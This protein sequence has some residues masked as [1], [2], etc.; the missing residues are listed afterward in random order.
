MYEK[1]RKNISIDTYESKQEAI[2]KETYE[3][4]ETKK[5]ER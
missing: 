3:Q 1:R 2:T 4:K 5:Y